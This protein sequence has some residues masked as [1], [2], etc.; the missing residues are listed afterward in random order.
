MS[1]QSLIQLTLNLLEKI[2]QHKEKVFEL[3]DEKA[4]KASSTRTTFRSTER[5][6]FVE[7]MVL[8]SVKPLYL[9]VH[10][11]MERHE[12]DGRKSVNSPVDFYDAVTKEFNN[13]EFVPFSRCLPHLNDRFSESTAHR[14]DKGLLMIRELAQKLLRKMKGPL[15]KL[16]TNYERSGNGDGMRRNDNSEI[17]PGF[18]V[19]N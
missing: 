3:A 7:C 4:A 1:S 6:R 14:L 15:A 8:D 17:A 13:E 19:T 10:E 5:M 9:K 2:D 12:L 16:V 18:D 11:V